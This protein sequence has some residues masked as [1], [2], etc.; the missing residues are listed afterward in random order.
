MP[1]PHAVPP[2]MKGFCTEIMIK[3]TCLVSITNINFYVSYSANSQNDSAS[4]SNVQETRLVLKP[5]MSKPARKDEPYVPC[6]RGKH[7][8]GDLVL[9]APK[10]ESAATSV[11]PEVQQDLKVWMSPKARS[12]T[13]NSLTST[14]GSSP[15]FCKR[16]K[17]M[18]RCWSNS[19]GRECKTAAASSTVVHSP[20]LTGAMQPE[21]DDIEG[22][23]F[24]SFTS[25]VKH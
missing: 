7:A 13:A 10:Q 18:N 8:L 11:A 6:I 25:K 2:Q 16:R 1:L 5:I 14:P 20:S 21:M 12:V 23:L 17:K 9:V 15:R 22:L 3:S 24:V 4:L 19:R